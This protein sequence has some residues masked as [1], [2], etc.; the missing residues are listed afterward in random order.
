[1]N[2]TVLVIALIVV[3]V[4]GGKLLMRRSPQV[5]KKQVFCAAAAWLGAVSIVAREMR[6]PTPG[7]WYYTSLVIGVIMGTFLLLALFRRLDSQRPTG[8]V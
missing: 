5:S 2:P 1:M 7:V 3:G 6:V 4:V 8:S